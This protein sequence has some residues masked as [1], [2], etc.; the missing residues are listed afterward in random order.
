MMLEVVDYLVAKQA[1]E[2]GISGLRATDD[3][4]QTAESD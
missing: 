1:A 3:G 4:S 2:R